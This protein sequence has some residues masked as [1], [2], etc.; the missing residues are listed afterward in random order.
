MQTIPVIYFSASNNT[1]Y[2]AELIAHG[3]RSQH[4]TAH[5]ISLTEADTYKHDIHHASI[6]C[7]GA[8]IYGG[9]Y[10]PPMQTWIENTDFT[11]K[12]VYLFST[13]AILFFGSFHRAKKLI[14]ERN[15]TV[16]GGFE[17]KFT[18]AGDGFFYTKRFSERFPLTKK[19][20]LTAYSYGQQIASSFQQNTT[21][22]LDY[23]KKHHLP[24]L[25]TF[26]V[27]H[28]LK[29]PL[30]FLFVHFFPRYDKKQCTVCKKCETICPTHAISI[31]NSMKRP[32]N[33]N[34]CIMCFQCAKHCSTNALYLT[35]NKKFIYYEGPWQ[36]KGYILPEEIIHYT[37]QKN[38]EK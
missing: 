8:P 23:T 22:F 21:T 1:K 29:D 35:K 13:A 12:T 38:S 2:L 28:L 36:L 14:E 30:V 6:L 33:P 17:M 25:T 4:L 27:K 32:I 3:I 18:A 11:G 26:V 5:L 24:D 10:A 31:T 37:K 9:D 19:D 16:L 15:G 34:H 7:I 20:I